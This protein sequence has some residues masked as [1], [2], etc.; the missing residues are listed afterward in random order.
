M[1]SVLIDLY[2]ANKPY[3][4][5]GQF[6]IN[7]HNELVTQA[8]RDMDF[9]FLCPSNFP[10]KPAAG[11]HYQK[12]TSL[13]RYL[14]SL[15]PKPKIWHHLHQFPSHKAHKQ[16][17]QLLTIHDLNFL[18]QKN[19][20]KAQS[21]LRR[22]QRN[23]D[24][25]EAI[26][27][28][29][30]FT[31]GEVQK[32][33]KLHNKPIHVVHNGVHLQSFKGAA[34][35]AYIGDSPFFFS[36]GIFS[37]KKNF[38]SLLPLLL[39]FPDYKLIIAGDCQTSYGEQIKTLAHKLGV[40]KQLVMPGKVSDA[41]K[42]WL[43]EHCRALLFPSL[44]EGFGLPVIEAFMA[45]KPVFLSNSSSLPEI[46]GHLANYWDNFEVDHMAGVLEKSLQFY[47]ANEA[48]QSLAFKKYAAQFSWKSCIENYLNIYKAL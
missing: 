24:Q 15:G 26:V 32:H 40:E 30:N 19:Q 35:P 29:S 39:K 12:A 21:Y 5:L 27:T 46:G 38:E 9:H 47:E 25:A 13:N 8:K 44:A 6:S 16:S 1:K 23:V 11:Y 31:K 4:G 36:L 48:S 14:P 18:T 2:K 22:L 41:D 43:Y 42:F 33:L 28:I 45:G 10:T 7:F 17:K 20:V 34:K 3:S 37:A